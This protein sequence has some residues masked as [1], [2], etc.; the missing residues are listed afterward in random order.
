MNELIPL[1]PQT[2]NGNIVETV[3]ARELHEFLGNGDMFA[4]WIKHRVEK[5]GFVE[6]QDFVSFLVSTKKPNGGRPS[7]EYYITLDMAKQLAM[8]EN[9]EKGMQVRKYFI[10]CEK[11]LKETITQKPIPL[12][13]AEALR[14]YADE[15]EAHERTQQQLAIAVPKAQYFDKLVERNLLTNFTTT[16]KEFGIKRKDFINY[17]LDN[18]YIYRDQQG[19]LLPYA[20]HVPHLFEVKEYSKD[21][22]SGVQTLVTPKGRETLRLLLT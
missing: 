18:G 15:V 12:T 4:N 2:I 1:Q 5:Y 20:V 13:F 10:E 14:A 8:V 22:H 19:N 3:S 11:K 17:L 6:N 9:N 21:V 16:T 7:Q